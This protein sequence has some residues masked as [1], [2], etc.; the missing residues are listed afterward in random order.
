MAKGIEQAFKAK[1][2]QSEQNRPALFRERKVSGPDDRTEDWDYE[3]LNTQ[4]AERTRLEREME[5]HR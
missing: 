5:N 3:A 4:P 1:E 2:A